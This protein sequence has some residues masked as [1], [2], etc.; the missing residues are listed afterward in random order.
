VKGPARAWLETHRQLGAHAEDFHSLRKRRQPSAVN[1]STTC[2]S[3][4]QG[5]HLANDVL[6][7]C[8]ALKVSMHQA[9]F[10]IRAKHGLLEIVDCITLDTVVQLK[11]MR[12][13]CPDGYIDALATHCDHCLGSCWLHKTYPQC[14]D[15]E[16]SRKV[17]KATVVLCMGIVRPK[18]AGN[19]GFHEGSSGTPVVYF[20]QTT[21]MSASSSASESQQPFTL[22]SVTSFIFPVRKQQT[23]GGFLKAFNDM[24]SNLKTTKTKTKRSRSPGYG[25]SDKPD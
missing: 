4:N 17:S 12:S 21:T 19:W 15:H 2:S 14:S 10:Q 6:D 13:P 9:G 24:E 18:S 25:G 11:V 3:A 22:V 16:S 5:Q 20:W 1:L 23:T 7:A 8:K